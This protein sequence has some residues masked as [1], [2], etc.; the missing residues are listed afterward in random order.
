MRWS[1]IRI[2]ITS[3]AHIKATVQSIGVPRLRAIMRFLALTGRSRRPEVL[4]QVAPSASLIS[5]SYDGP[6]LAAGC[7]MRSTSLA[8]SLLALLGCSGG[9][10]YSGKGATG[11]S[12]SSDAIAP[13]TCESR[14]V[15]TEAA[16]MS[17][18]APQKHRPTAACCP[19]QR[20]P[21]PSGQPYSP[22]SGAVGTTCP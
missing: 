16:A 13:V 3:S 5:T 9:T 8:L 18:A 21:G 11:D 17:A 12:G 19:A 6:S 2:P 1:T 15:D 10:N 22:C 4:A 7:F 14:L 20:G